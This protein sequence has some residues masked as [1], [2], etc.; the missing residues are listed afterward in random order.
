[1][2]S[3]IAQTTLSSPVK[4]GT[5]SRAGI[6]VIPALTPPVKKTPITPKMPPIQ[7]SAVNTPINLHVTFAKNLFTYWLLF[8]LWL[9]I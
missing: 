1:M 7:I 4:N 9:I 3:Y 5:N 8:L 6:T 2:I